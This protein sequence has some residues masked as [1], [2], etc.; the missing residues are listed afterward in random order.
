MLNEFGF[1]RE[2]LYICIEYRETTA[3]LPFLLPFWGRNNLRT[4]E[5]SDRR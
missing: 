5:N 3:V 4:C 2:M 1:R